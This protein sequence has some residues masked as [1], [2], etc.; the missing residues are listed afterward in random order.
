[1][2][3]LRLIEALVEDGLTSREIAE[4]LG[5]SEAAIRNLRYRKRLIKKAKNE[6]KVLPHR[7]NQ[8]RQSIF[9]L[10]TKQEELEL[11][12]QDLES[13]KE[14]MERFL[15][16][17]KSQLELVLT[18]ALKALKWKRPEIFTLSGPEQFVMLLSLFSKLSS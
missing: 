13:K 15:Q 8:L 6:T 10:E 2:E 7:R 11:A 5:R 16:L 17:D 1:M 4:R 9:S 3:E 18:E 12:V 14:S